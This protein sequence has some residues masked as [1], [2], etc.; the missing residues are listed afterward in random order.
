MAVLLDHDDLEMLLSELARRLH[1]DGVA[2]SRSSDTRELGADASAGVAIV[3]TRK[4]SGQGLR[5]GV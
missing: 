1:A 4:R 5:R 3:A 2:A